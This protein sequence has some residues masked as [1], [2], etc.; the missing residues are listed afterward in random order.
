[1]KSN[2]Q[3]VIPE[4]LNNYLERKCFYSNKE[5]FIDLLLGF[6]SKAEMSWSNP[7]FYRSYNQRSFVFEDGIKKRTIKLTQKYMSS[8]YIYSND[9]NPFEFILGFLADGKVYTAV[10]SGVASQYSIGSCSVSDLDLSEDIPFEYINMIE[11]DGISF[12]EH[13][14]ADHPKWFELLKTTEMSSEMFYICPELAVLCENGYVEFCNMFY[15]SYS[16]GFVKKIKAFR[17]LIAKGTSIEE[18]LQCKENFRKI[19]RMMEEEDILYDIEAIAELNVMNNAA[20]LELDILKDLIIVEF[21][22]L[23]SN[24]SSANYLKKTVLFILNYKE[25]GK[26]IYSSKLLND[27]I[28]R[29]FSNYKPTGDWYWDCYFNKTE[30]AIANLFS[31]IAF[32][33]ATGIQIKGNKKINKDIEETDEKLFENNKKKYSDL[34]FAITTH[35]YKMLKAFSENVPSETVMN[36]QLAD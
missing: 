1:M 20:D 24:F 26:T 15:D 31:C 8:K 19:L 3:C 35:N 11:W 17:K 16:R 14:S 28:H 9:N 22:S 27:Y 5:L 6:F 30:H 13:L 2:N 7:Y 10:V 12:E 18:I 4:K 34:H 36:K 23:Q 25:K 21:P 32:C 33:Y 29:Y